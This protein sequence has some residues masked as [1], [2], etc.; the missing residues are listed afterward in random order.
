MLNPLFVGL[1][2]LKICLIRQCVFSAP[3][4]ATAEIYNGNTVPPTMRAPENPPPADTAVEFMKRFGYLDPGI[5]NSEALYREDA[6]IEAI[7]N[8]QKFGAIPQTGILDSNTLQLMKRKRCGVPDVI[9]RKRIKRYIV[10]S[11]GWKK[12]N[13]TYFIANWT[14]KLGE[15]NVFHEM[16]KAFNSW[17]GYARLSF[18][19]SRDPNAD[20]IIAFGR[21]PHGDYYPFDGP[22]NILAHAYFPYEHG[23]YGGDIHFDDDEEWKMRP[24]E[25]ESGVDF[26]TVAVHELGHSLGLA[27]SPVSGSI[28]FPYYKGYQPNFQLDYDDILAM[29]ELYISRNLEGDT[30]VTHTNTNDVDEEFDDYTESNGDEHEKR[31]TPKPDHSDTTHKT[32]DESD[33]TESSTSVVPIPTTL[34]PEYNV[35]YMGDDES[36]DEHLQHDSTTHHP[37]TKNKIPNLCEG[38][39]NAISVLRNELFVFKDKYVWRMPERNEVIPGYPVPIHQLFWSLPE[40]VTAIDAVYQRE[41]DQSIVLFTGNQYWVHDGDKFIENSPRP[42]TSYGLPS[43]LKKV[44]AAFVWGKNGKTFIFSG[45]QYWR[46]NE[47]TQKMDPGYPHNVSRWRGV[48][49]DLDA[50]FTWTDGL[51]YF[52]KNNIFWRFNNYLIKTDRGYPLLASQ[53]WFNCS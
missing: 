33:T 28:M 35:T 41:T 22:G 5:P 12:R 31:T 16:Q 20:I 14:P 15:E 21:G 48:P 37:K 29:Y 11:E 24:G 51:T 50:A 47:T 44:D 45:H 39:P 46:Y 26:F 10:G 6:I 36:V 18:Q 4:P 53:Y 25:L 3:L 7:K 17:S 43:T 30:S 42:I 13:I 8:M 19:Y 2:L 52:F 38:T 9:R 23:N 32:S 49:E 34:Q 27:H 40:F 1:V